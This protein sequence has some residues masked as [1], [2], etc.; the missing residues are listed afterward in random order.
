[1]ELECVPA[2]DA[3]HDTVASTLSLCTIP[4]DRAAVAEVRRV[5][6][7]GGRFVLLEHVRSP[8]RAVRGVQRL[9]ARKPGPG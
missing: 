6:R 3:R 5:L 8:V 2:L 9:L 4:D 7:S 1:L